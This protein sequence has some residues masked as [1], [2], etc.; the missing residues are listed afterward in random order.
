MS[1]VKN[2]II[3]GLL[4][5]GLGGGFTAAGETVNHTENKQELLAN[6]QAELEQTQAE[7]DV[8]TVRLGE[9]CVSAM[10]PYLS[11]GELSGSEEDSVVSDII[12]NGQEPCGDSPTDI[13]VAYRQLDHVYSSNKFWEGVVENSQDSLDAAIARDQEGFDWRKML[14]VASIT[15]T[16][17]AGAVTMVSLSLSS[18]DPH[19]NQPKHKL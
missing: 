14:M 18:S 12:L 1:R 2:V 3:G 17:A 19:I 16:L 8:V 13:R 5:A 9:A 10:R 6:D 11:G 7:L 15:G 4:G